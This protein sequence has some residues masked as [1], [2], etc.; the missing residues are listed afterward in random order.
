MWSVDLLAA[1]FMLYLHK[2]K[3]M[4]YE[5]LSVRLSVSNFYLPNRQPVCDKGLHL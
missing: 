1:A 3:P 4:L 5:V 2:L